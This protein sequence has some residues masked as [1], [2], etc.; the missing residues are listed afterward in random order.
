MEIRNK[1]MTSRWVALILSIAMIVLQGV[2]PVQ[3]ATAE[4]P[5]GEHEWEL[6]EYYPPTC[7][8]EGT[9]V[10]CC[11]KCGK[12]IDESIPATGHY[13]TEWYLQPIYGQFGDVIQQDCTEGVSQYRYCT[14]CGETEY[15][16]R[17]PGIHDFDQWVTIQTPTCMREGINGH[18]CKVCGIYEQV[19]TGYG[20]HQYGNWVEAQPATCT[21]QGIY[22]H[23]CIY[24]GNRDYYYTDKAAH[25]YGNWVE[26]KAPTCSE[27][28]V[29]Y[30][31][32]NV[33]GYREYYY[34]DKLAHT[35]GEWSVV[36]EPTD[37]TAGLAKRVCEVCGYEEEYT[38]YP[39]GTLLYGDYNMEVYNFQLAL[40]NAGYDI[41]VAG[42]RFGDSTRGAVVAF[43]QDH[44]LPEDGIGWPGIQKMLAGEDI[45]GDAFQGRT[46]AM[47]CSVKENK[48]NAPEDRDFYCAGEEVIIWVNISSPDR[49]YN[50][51]FYEEPDR[52]QILYDTELYPDYPEGTPWCADLNSR[53]SSETFTY[54]HII[55]PEE[56]EAGSYVFRVYA[57]GT[58]QQ[59]NQIKSN[60]A[61]LEV[62]T[63]VIKPSRFRNK[64]EQFPTEPSLELRESSQAGHVTEGIPDYYY[65]AL[66]DDV[67]YKLIVTNETETPFY[68]IEI[69]SYW[70][71]SKVELAG[72]LASD[73]TE[74]FG[75]DENDSSVNEGDSFAGDSDSFGGD[76]DSFAG[77]DGS[78]TDESE[79]FTGDN[80]SFD[81]GD[82]SHIRAYLPAEDG[83]KTIDI[84]M[85]PGL[86]NFDVLEPGETIVFYIWLNVGSIS[87]DRDTMEREFWM[88]YSDPEGIE[89]TVE[90]NKCEVPIGL[91]P[92]SGSA[93]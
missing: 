23:D 15:R 22:Y 14:V 56:A 85:N 48:A 12:W 6:E 50:V 51:H 42:G 9:A 46:S 68:D 16:F 90:S 18:T 47:E 86:I 79:G 38:W 28:G 32:C 78:V 37:F 88:T 34:V 66:G 43:E 61:E 77:E 3:A 64:Q 11:I 5:E 55:T 44:D 31:D 59:R 53:Q 57:F 4:C 25:T 71:P 45:P 52:E 83:T 81:D 91:I 26:E 67:K 33:C 1:R 63:G 93:E 70:L 60:T 75:N 65:Y 73:E 58:D 13:W 2:L 17:E 40:I 41:N 87:G 72:A 92:E 54:R 49:I 39:D 69:G 84:Y 19:S 21:R 30:R 27:Q 7:E 74:T 89:G 20:D 35:F 24:C 76:S 10:Y 82:D 8:D 29:Y 36:A 80:D 62:E